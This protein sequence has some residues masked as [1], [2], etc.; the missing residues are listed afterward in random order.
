[1]QAHLIP[2]VQGVCTGGFQ[3]REQCFTASVEK[4]LVPIVRVGYELHVNGLQY[5]NYKKTGNCKQLQLSG[6]Y[7]TK[8]DLS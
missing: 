6:Q 1:M 5:L 7:K 2:L 4:R 3:D 8:A